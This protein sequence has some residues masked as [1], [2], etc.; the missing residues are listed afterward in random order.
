MHGLCCWQLWVERESLTWR[1]KKRIK[2]R[3]KETN[4][5]KERKKQK[6]LTILKKKLRERK[7]NSKKNNNNKTLRETEKRNK[8]E[9]NTYTNLTFT[10]TLIVLH[11]YLLTLFSTTFVYC[12]HTYI[13][14]YTFSTPSKLPYEVSKTPTLPTVPH[15]SPFQPTFPRTMTV[16]PAAASPLS[17]PRAMRK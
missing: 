3:K 11:T 17:P 12:L 8:M 1:D 9:Y 13:T 16:V 4:K 15:H 2:K 7:H 14:L 10:Y 5:K 6:K